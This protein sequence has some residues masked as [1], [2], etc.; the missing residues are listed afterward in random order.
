MAFCT[1]CGASLGESSKFCPQCGAATA[2][3]AAGPVGTVTTTETS[4]TGA[5]AQPAMQTAPV[6]KGGGSALKI[7]LIIF[8]VIVGLFVLAGAV[9][10]FGIWRFAHKTHIETGKDHARIE[11]P[12]GTVESNGDATA[13]M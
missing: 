2:L 10:G 6:Q 8:G 1:S 12:F 13:A 7:I 9:V 4:P 3:P 11:T 5:A